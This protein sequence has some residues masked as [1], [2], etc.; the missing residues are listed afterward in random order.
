VQ[1]IALGAGQSVADV[2]GI[3]HSILVICAKPLHRPEAQSVAAVQVVQSCASAAPSPP[4]SPAPL[5]D[6]LLL[7]V[8]LLLPLLLAVPL[9]LPLLLAVPLLLP[10]D[11]PLL[12]PPELLPLLEPLSDSDPELEPLPV[13]VPPDELEHA[14]MPRAKSVEAPRMKIRTSFIPSRMTAREPQK[15][16]LSTAFARCFTR[17][18]WVS[19]PDAGV[20]HWQVAVDRSITYTCTS[21]AANA[22]VK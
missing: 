9:L 12:D 15:K 4:A 19:Q 2:H 20:D 10:L 16:A 6:P 11:P 14:G 1:V 17:V 18:G 13:P 21:L 22:S 5:D 8:P 7:A 3:V